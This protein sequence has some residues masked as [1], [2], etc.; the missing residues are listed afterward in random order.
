MNQEIRY[1]QASDG[2]RSK[3]ANCSLRPT[4]GSPRGSTRLIWKA[5]AHFERAL[6]VARQQH[7]YAEIAMPPARPRGSRPLHQQADEVDANE[8]LFRPTRQEL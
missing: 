8:I 6:A 7:F 2:G 1:C 5:E 4:G 3:L